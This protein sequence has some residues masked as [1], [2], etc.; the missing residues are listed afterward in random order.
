MFQIES[1]FNIEGL[2]ATLRRLEAGGP[3]RGVDHPGPQISAATLDALAPE[4]IDG[5]IKDLSEP[6]G[7]LAELEYASPERRLMARYLHANQDVLLMSWANA[8]DRAGGLAVKGLPSAAAF[9]ELRDE[10]EG[11]RQIVRSA[12]AGVNTMLDVRLM[13]GGL[14]WF[15]LGAVLRVVIAKLEDPATP[16]DESAELSDAF[17]PILL[18]KD[19][20]LRDRET[21]RAQLEADQARL[22]V[23]LKQAEDEMVLQDVMHAI[24]MQ[25]PVHPQRMAQA[26]RVMRERKA[27]GQPVVAGVAAGASIGASISASGTTASG[28]RPLV[29]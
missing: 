17:G 23:E 13:L 3:L 8:C 20:L 11:Y 12:A 4:T 19:Q 2:A 16:A 27:A 25:L 14:M 6:A 18:H 28:R 29:R 21:E 5:Y 1:T 7:R 26:L 9:S 15:T 10:A 22:Q 24:R